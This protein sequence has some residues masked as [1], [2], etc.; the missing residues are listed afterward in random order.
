MQKQRYITLWITLR[1]LF[2]LDIDANLLQRL[3]QFSSAYRRWQM[4]FLLK[5]LLSASPLHQF[6]HFGWFVRG[7]LL[8]MGIVTLV[9]HSVAKFWESRKIKQQQSET[10]Q[11]LDAA[12]RPKDASSS[13]AISFNN[14][15]VIA[16]SKIW[17]SRAH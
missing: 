10:Q 12:T 9:Y 4:Q 7:H 13:A 6:A 3:A 5:H 11:Q 16:T 2:S 15:A 17:R 1:W 8:K 14:L